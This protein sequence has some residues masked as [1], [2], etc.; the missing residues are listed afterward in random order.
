VD[1]LQG[2]FTV[3][4]TLI[5]DEPRQ[6]GEVD[7]VLVGVKAWQV[8]EAAQAIQPMVGQQTYVVP[9]QNGVDAPGQLASVLGQEHVLGGMCQ[10]SSLLVGP[11][12]IRHVGLEPRVV[13]GELSGERSERA[14]Q[15]L[16]AFEFTV[17]VRAEVSPD[18]QA[19]MWRKFLFIAAI[20]GVG[21]VTRAPVGINCS[22]P[23]T[24]QILVQAMQ[25]IY[26][27]ARHI[28]IHLPEDI[29]QQTLAFID[30][31]E[32]TIVPSMQ[33]DL[34]AGWPSELAAQIGAVLR[35]GSEVGIPTPVH[36]F[37][38]S[39]LLPQELKAR[40]EIDF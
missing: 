28:G 35:M 6:A 15:L 2:D 17:G 26:S 23:E 8:P 31:L 36:A 4:P 9:L 30:S 1:S 33:R 7:V 14:E 12:H 21:A 40:K 16:R 10:I 34:M 27:L 11:G 39:A 29:V 5:T 38:Y 37:L 3:R 25:E 18:I 19:A 24:R 32:P 20:S 22:V 13:F